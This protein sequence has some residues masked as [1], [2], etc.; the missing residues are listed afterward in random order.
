MHGKVGAKGLRQQ[1]RSHQLAL[2]LSSWQQ[3]SH[4]EQLEKIVADNQLIDRFCLS[5]KN[6]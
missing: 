2:S 3:I 1:R 5:C 6:C 4:R